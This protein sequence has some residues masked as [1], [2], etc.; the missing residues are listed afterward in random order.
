MRALWQRPRAERQERRADELE[1]NQAQLAAANDEL[2]AQQGELDRTVAAL[3]AEKERVE[4]LLRF[5]EGL[6][7]ET[8]L[9]PLCELALRDVCDFAGAEVGTLYVASDD[10]EPAPTL[11]AVRGLERDRLP[12]RLTPGKG[13][14]PARAL[15]ERRPVHASYGDTS[16]RLLAF[17]EEISVR[18]EAHLPL[19]QGDRPIGVLTLA[20]LGHVPF[21]PAELD[22]LQ[23][24]CDEAAVALANALSYRTA[25]RLANV[26]RAVIDATPDG[27]LLADL[28]GRRL[29][30]NAAMSR[31]PHE[32]GATADG[33]VYSRIA[34]VAARLREPERFL[35][36]IQSLIEDAER[37]AQLDLD[38]AD[39]GES[40]YVYTAPVRDE[41]GTATA[42]IFV[43]RDVTA[44]REAERLKTEL[45]ST[46]SHELRTPLASIL[47]FSELMTTREFD[48]DTRSRF[49]G[50]IHKEARR[51]TDLINDFLDLQ[52]IE[53]GRFTLDLRP[54]DLRELLADQA[55]LFAGQSEAHELVLDVPEGRL[56]VLGERD[57][58][59][60]VVANLVSNAIKY[61]PAGGRVE[62]AAG[63]D[64]GYVRISVRD[65]G[66]GIPA[67]QQSGIFGKFFR[68]DSSDT[69]EIGGTGLGLALAREIV[70]AHGGQIGFES[71]EGEGS[72]FWF[73]LASGPRPGTRRALVIED[74]PSAASLL[75]AYL[76]EEGLAVEVVRSGEGGL[77]RAREEPPA[78]VCLDITLAGELDGW[79]VL[80]RLKEEPATADVPVVVCTAG[81]GREWAGVLGAADFV[82]KPFSAE[83]LRTAAQRVL[84]S[85]G[86]SVLVVDDEEPV[87]RLVIEALQSDTVELR[88]AADGEEA[89]AE[90][91]RLRPDVVVLDLAMPKLD[92][93]GVLERLQQD[94]RTR[95]L[96]VIVLTARRL[97]AS[98]RHQLS[99]RV[100]SLLEKSSYSAQDLRRVVSQA[101]GRS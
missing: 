92:G 5:S 60:Q 91:R 4:R 14:L 40:F 37:E 10:R 87:R 52:R 55:D 80:A 22:T 28:E 47:G 41:S 84:G 74:D 88:E 67:D 43:M 57:R 89:L 34:D 58:V 8:E 31:M 75:S 82:T 73:E 96:P 71:R 49:L 68:V 93:L 50:T 101:L 13:G 98:E 24:L 35:A 1:E 3:E 45:L 90:I 29:L 39:T 19:V 21:S 32:L 26:N 100:V 70:E 59:A 25:R 61:S 51:L 15:A 85:N 53:Q 11:A 27:I 33:A 79:Q 81:N 64:D 9:E 23:A 62:V 72:T 30:E 18:H 42:R 63:V 97:S 95:F 38:F 66:L 78:L 7:A 20:R 48:D 99:D 36:T 2:E 12:E 65:C 16:L 56:E 86:G 6:A 77:A 44:Q 17:G 83:Q 46:V 76:E 94:A 54:F 69:R